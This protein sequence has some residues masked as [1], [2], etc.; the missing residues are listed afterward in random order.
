MSEQETSLSKQDCRRSPYILGII[1]AT[2]LYGL[3]LL[4]P[5]IR[6]PKR[7]AMFLCA[8]F[9]VWISV[10]KLRKL[11]HGTG[12]VFPRTPTA[13]LMALAAGAWLYLWFSH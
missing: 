3:S 8:S 11:I 9:V 7:W 2:L 12:W 10:L 5:A 4:E 13:L 6:G 1:A